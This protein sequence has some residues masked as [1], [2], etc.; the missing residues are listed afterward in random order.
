[1][2]RN[3]AKTTPYFH[4]GSVAKLVEA[5]QVMADV[6]FGDRL[7]DQDAAAIAAFFGALTGHVPSH[8]SPPSK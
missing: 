5:V 6:Q 8:F 3:I 1:M 7:S 2:L 4:D